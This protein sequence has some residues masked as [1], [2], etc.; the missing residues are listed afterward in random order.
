ME[1]QVDNLTTWT[2][3]I[4]HNLNPPQSIIKGNIEKHI[5]EWCQNDLYD[6]Q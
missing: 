5:I 4:Y 6:N 2:H 1:D 3:K